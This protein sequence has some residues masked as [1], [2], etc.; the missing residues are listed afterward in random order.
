[1]PTEAQARLATVLERADARRLVRGSDGHQPLIT[2]RSKQSDAD[3]HSARAARV[4]GI[5]GPRVI[6]R[7][8][9]SNALGDE[10][11]NV[12]AK[13]LFGI[14]VGQCAGTASRPRMRAQAA[15]RGIASC[16]APF[17]HLDGP[18]LLGRTG[19]DVRSG[20]HC[21]RNA[22]RSTC[23]SN[24]ASRLIMLLGIGSCHVFRPETTKTRLRIVRARVAQ[25]L[26]SLW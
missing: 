14:A 19:I 8:S 20:V 25:M 13:P 11:V 24:R 12:A 10:L 6:A 26:P 21:R 15:G 17:I 4:S 7:R 3:S 2:G 16:P 23:V 22:E 18:R 1:M 5:R 9:A